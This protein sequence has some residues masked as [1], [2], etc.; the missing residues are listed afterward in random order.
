MCRKGETIDKVK[1]IFSPFQVVYNCF[2]DE[3]GQATMYWH[4]VKTVLGQLIKCSSLKHTG[5]PI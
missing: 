5:Y 2:F 1:L 4:D 3:T